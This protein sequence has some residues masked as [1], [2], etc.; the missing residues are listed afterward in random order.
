M[1]KTTKLGTF[2]PLL[3]TKYYYGEKI[4]KNV[5]ERLGEKCVHDFGG[6]TRRKEPS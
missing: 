4:T 6:E 1:E 5:T 3:L 2:R